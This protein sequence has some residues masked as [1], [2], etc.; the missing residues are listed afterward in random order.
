M[1]IEYI[2]IELKDGISSVVARCDT[3]QEAREHLINDESRY[4][5]CIN[6]NQFK[7]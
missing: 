2:V 7:D 6:P 4:I 5:N 1:S 3:L